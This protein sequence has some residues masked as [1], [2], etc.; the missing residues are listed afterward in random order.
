MKHT[1]R[2]KQTSVTDGLFEYCS[3]EKKKLKLTMAITGIT[4]IA[5]VIGGLLTNSL[6]LVSNAGHMFTHFFA[7]VGRYFVFYHDSIWRNYNIFYT[8]EY[9]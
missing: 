6:A 5:E 8:L 4:M 3:I 1:H 7:Y 2:P 9:Y